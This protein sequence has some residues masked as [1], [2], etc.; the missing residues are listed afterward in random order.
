MKIIT[1]LTA[2]ALGLTATASLAQ[3]SVVVH[4]ADLD[5]ASPEGQATLARRISRAADTVCGATNGVTDLGTQRAQR[6]CSR[7][8][9]ATAMKTLAEKAAPQFAAR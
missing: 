8:A 6:N 4:Y 1:I 7:Q 2:A 3:T 9:Q 5:I